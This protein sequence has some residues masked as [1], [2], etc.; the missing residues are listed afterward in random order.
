MTGRLRAAAGLALLALAAPACAQT[1]PGA[2]P[3]VTAQDC[4][5]EP[6]PEGGTAA[7]EDLAAKLD[8]CNGVLQPPPTGDAEIGEPAPGGGETPVIPPGALPEQPPSGG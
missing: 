6:A 2:E 3:G 4:L 5:A 1:A 8:K 7:P